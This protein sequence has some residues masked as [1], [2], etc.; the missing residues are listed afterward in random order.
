MAATP[1][2]RFNLRLQAW[3]RRNDAYRHPEPPAADAARDAIA[4]ASEACKRNM[5]ALASELTDWDPSDRVL[6]AELHRELGEF[7]KAKAILGRFRGRSYSAGDRRGEAAVG[8]PLPGVRA[9]AGTL[10]ASR[11]AGFRLRAGLSV[12]PLPCQNGPDQPPKAL[13]RNRCP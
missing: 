4:S 8:V 12:P 5:E 6:N 1:R 13:R 2:Q 10:N 7:A 3:W 9:R 11:H